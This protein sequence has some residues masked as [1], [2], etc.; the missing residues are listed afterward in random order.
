VLACI[1]PSE[2]GTLTEGHFY[3][4]PMLDGTWQVYGRPFPVEPVIVSGSV[5]LSAL[6]MLGVETLLQARQDYLASKEDGPELLPIPP[7]SVRAQQRGDLAEEL[8][9]KFV[10]GDQAGTGNHGFDIL[11]PDGQLRIQVKS[12]VRN[13]KS[14]LISTLQFKSDPAWTGHDELFYVEFSEYNYPVTVW[15]IDSNRLREAISKGTGVNDGK[16]HQVEDLLRNRGS[17]IT[18]QVRAFFDR[19]YLAGAVND[20][21]GGETINDV[22]VLGSLTAEITLGKSKEQSKFRH[23]EGFDAKW[24]I[25]K[26]EIDEISANNPN[27]VIWP[28]SDFP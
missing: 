26:A 12:S 21:V 7:P 6:A 16:T 9:A 14:G 5:T 27:A 19:H 17:D 8:I 1:L 23:L 15:V 18:G 20:E 28:I 3:I 10:G 13:K 2:D 22:D 11:G 24:D 25:L 4:E